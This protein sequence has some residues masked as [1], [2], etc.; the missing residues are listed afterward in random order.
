VLCCTVCLFRALC[1]LA[2]AI[3]TCM[4]VGRLAIGSARHSGTT[5]P[6]LT[7]IYFFFFSV[8]FQINHKDIYLEVNRNNEKNKFLKT[9]SLMCNDDQTLNQSLCH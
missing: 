3:C 5:T 4:C 1:A 6:G 2:L 7:T 8:F 9:H